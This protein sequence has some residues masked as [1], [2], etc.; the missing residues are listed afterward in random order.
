MKI[1][2]ISEIM[3]ISEGGAKSMLFKAINNIRK[4]MKDKKNDEV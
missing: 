3:G 1:S 2:E 4:I